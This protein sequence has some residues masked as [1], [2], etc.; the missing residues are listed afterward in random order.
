MNKSL[1]RKILFDFKNQLKN[2]CVECIVTE[3]KFNCFP[4]KM[5]IARK[6]FRKRKCSYSLKFFP[7]A[8]WNIIS[9]DQVLN[10][11][12]ERKKYK[13]KSLSPW[14]AMC[15]T[16]WYVFLLLLLSLQA[17]K[18]KKVVQIFKL[19]ASINFLTKFVHICAVSSNFWASI[20]PSKYK[21]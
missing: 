14:K 6:M 4:V 3:K 2:Y 1:H 12:N 11:F 17:Y 8:L 10:G 18:K 16:V 13:K 20:T 9:K 15:F 21:I 7:V 5:R 19:T